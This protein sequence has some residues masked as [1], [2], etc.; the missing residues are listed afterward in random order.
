M[1]PTRLWVRTCVEWTKYVRVYES[2][3]AINHTVQ[4][5]RPRRFSNSIP[6]SKEMRRL[7]YRFRS[8]NKIYDVASALHFVCC[9][10]GAFSRSTEPGSVFIFVVTVKPGHRVG[11]VVFVAALRSQIEVVVGAV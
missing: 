2:N 4:Q 7:R 6:E 1:R 10:G 9:Q 5:T 8:Y 11:Q 3:S